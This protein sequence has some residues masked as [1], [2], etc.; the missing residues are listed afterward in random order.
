MRLS[1]EEIEKHMSALKGWELAGNEIRKLYV[2]DTFGSA[3]TFVSRVATLAEE[4][5]HHPD[6]LIQYKKVTLT[7]TSHDSGGLTQRDFGLA[8]RIDG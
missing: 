5:D 3:M 6:F 2:F 8:H 1:D 7:L 4:A